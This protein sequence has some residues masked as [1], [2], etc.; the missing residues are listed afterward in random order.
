MC[1]P[2]FGLQ[3]Y[4]AFHIEFIGYFESYQRVEL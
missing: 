1:V 4:A 3:I 2:G